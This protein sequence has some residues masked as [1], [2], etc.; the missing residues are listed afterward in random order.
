MGTRSPSVV[1]LTGDEDE[2]VDITDPV[3]TSHSL[4]VESSEAETMFRPREM[5]AVEVTERMC[6]RIVLTGVTLV[7]LDDGDVGIS[8]GRIVIEK[9]APEL[10]STR[11][12]GKNLSE[13]T[14]LR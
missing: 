10:K 3:G 6:E 7:P 12:D 11:E 8:A 9:S 1:A 4:I 13:V 2:R 5:M 14:L